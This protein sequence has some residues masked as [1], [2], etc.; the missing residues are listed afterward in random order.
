ML[1]SELKCKKMHYYIWKKFRLRLNS[2]QI[3]TKF[4]IDLFR[5]KVYFFLTDTCIGIIKSSGVRKFCPNSKF[6]DKSSAGLTSV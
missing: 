5:I 6:P 2:F 3:R 1:L 4:R